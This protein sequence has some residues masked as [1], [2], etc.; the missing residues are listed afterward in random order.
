MEF[1]FLQ[2]EDGSPTL[3][4]GSKPLTEAEAMHSS[5]GAFA[6]TVYIYGH[7][8]ST[9]LKHNL[10]PS[11]LSLG[12]GLGYNELL[13]TALLLQN[14][15]DLSKVRGESFE[16]VPELNE[17]FNAWLTNR[18]VS[19]EFQKTYDQIL[20]LCAEHTKQEQAL[21]KAALANL[22]A[23]RSWSLN[24]PL[25]SETQTSYQLSCFLFDAFSS[26]TSPELW[27]EVFINNFL[28]TTAAKSAVLATYACTGTLKRA[29]QKNDFTVTI[30][31]G[32]AGKRES[33]FATRGISL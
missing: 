14:K 6:E 11:F 21:I 10:N 15:S 26:K 1:H 33:T 19:N 12:L 17:N 4:L 32:F 27:S 23:Q 13:T 9:T 16:L 20:S 5:K 29:L 18:N 2:T 24:G 3:K 22:V 25:T 7:A 30:R 8:I 28:A 31:N